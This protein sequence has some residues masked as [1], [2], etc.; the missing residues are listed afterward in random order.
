MDTDKA[1]FG[2]EQVDKGTIVTELKANHIESYN[3]NDY[4]VWKMMFVRGVGA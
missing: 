1:T 4:T 3:I 2:R